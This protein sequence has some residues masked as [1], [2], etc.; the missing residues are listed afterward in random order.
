MTDVTGR[1]DVLV[2]ALQTPS[3]FHYDCPPQ[4]T[5]DGR[6]LAAVRT[7]LLDPVASTI[8]TA[9]VTFNR[10]GQDARK[11]FTFPSEAVGTYGGGGCPFSWQRAR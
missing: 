9:L 8:A 2:R 5:P 4:W 3:R 1:N 7:E 11:A 10:S 6:R